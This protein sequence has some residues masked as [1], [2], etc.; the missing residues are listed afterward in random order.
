[1]TSATDPIPSAV[2]SIFAF[3]HRTAEPSEAGRCWV[4]I[5]Y[6]N[7]PQRDP[8]IFNGV[9]GISFFLVDYYRESGRPEA[10]VLAQDAIDWCVAFRGKHFVRG[11]HLGKTGVALAAL[12]KSI[13]LGESIV[14]GY[15]LENARV[16]LREPAGPVTDLLGGEASNGL[17]LLKL[18]A[19]TQDDE[20]LCGAN[21]CAGWIESKITRIR[22]IGRG[23]LPPARAR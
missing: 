21:R 6:E 4:T 15:C 5:D 20:H 13:A 17:F 19:R 16:I 2:D 14:P 9:G 12:H 23:S 22:R 10:L 11:L 1:M 18:W 3:I 7:K 8:G